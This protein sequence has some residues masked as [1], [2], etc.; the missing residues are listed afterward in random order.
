MQLPRRIIVDRASLTGVLIVPK[1]YGL[2]IPL[3]NQLKSDSIMCA[4][5]RKAAQRQFKMST[6]TETGLGIMSHVKRN[7]IQKFRVIKRLLKSVLKT[8]LA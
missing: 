1:I 3:S 7:G 5:M 6:T 2:L 8:S 4:E